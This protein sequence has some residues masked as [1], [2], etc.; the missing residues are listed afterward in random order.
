MDLILLSVPIFFALMGAEWLV[1]RVRGRPIFRGPDVFANL[2]LGT[3]QTVFA[4]VAAG[5]L[6]SG[7]LA[8][9]DYRLW[10]VPE[11]SVGAWIALLFGV[12]FL[13]YWFHRAS[14]RINLAWATHAPHH[15]SED[16]NLAVAL[17]Q[18]P[19]QP[20]ISRIF[21]LPLA[22]LGFSPAMFAT[23]FSLNAI[24]QFWIH[25]ELIGKLGPLE[26][27]LNTPSHH[28]VH[29]GCN[30]RYLDK[31]HAGIFILWDR[32]FGSFA[33]EQERPTYGTVKPINSFNPLLAAI[34]PFR[35]IFT[36]ARRAPRL[37]DKLKIWVMPP[38]WRPRGLDDAKLEV[39]ATMLDL[40]FDPVLLEL[41]RHLVQHVGIDERLIVEALT[42]ETGVRGDRED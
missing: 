31:N 22:W 42:V 21:V 18:G 12:D 11:S 27:V 6:A 30:D 35:E 38:E 25:T 3:A 5:F 33:A 14:H 1:G 8:L 39:A 28:R 40:E 26:W 41:L 7:Y 4:A 32:M 9:Y 36:L 24:Y 10:D 16:Y 13:Y 37:V 15:Q 34:A 20:V 17:R 29:H 2:A 19:V 23:M